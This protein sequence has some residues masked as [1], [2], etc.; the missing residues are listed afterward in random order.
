MQF[1]IWAR[2]RPVNGVGSKYEQIGHP[3]TD[4]RQI[5][6]MIDQVDREIYMEA[7]CVRTEWQKM[8]ECVSYQE[9]KKYEPY[10]KKKVKSN[11]HTQPR[12]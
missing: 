5:Q 4:E 6:F 2:K 9:F 3:F 11:N 1:E 7:M 8:P 10:V 12:L